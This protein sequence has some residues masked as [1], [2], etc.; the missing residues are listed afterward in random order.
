MSSLATVG[1][2]KTT[3]ENDLDAKDVEGWLK[4]IDFNSS[5]RQLMLKADGYKMY[6][7]FSFWN[8]LNHL[9]Q[10]L[11]LENQTTAESLFSVL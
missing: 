3:A 10:S 1:I 2:Y 8:F 5:S 6:S 4:S 11:F 9:Q 7:F